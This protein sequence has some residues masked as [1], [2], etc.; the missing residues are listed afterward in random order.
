MTILIFCSS[1]A[2]RHSGFWSQWVEGKQ[3][4]L[5]RDV[6]K[7]SWITEQSTCQKNYQWL[8]HCQLHCLVLTITVKK[9]KKKKKNTDAK[10]RV[11]WHWPSTGHKITIGKKWN[12]CILIFLTSLSFTILRYQLQSPCTCTVYM[13]LPTYWFHYQQPKIIFLK[14]KSAFLH[15]R[16]VIFDIAMS[17]TKYYKQKDYVFR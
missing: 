10:G 2:A 14:R 11:G 9:R 15:T 8:L 5:A 17:I 1:V 13:H 7:A 16:K 6:A 4:S 3:Q 12:T